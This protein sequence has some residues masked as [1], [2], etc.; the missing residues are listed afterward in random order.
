M[1]RQLKM[2]TLH[3]SSCTVFVSNTYFI[4][5]IAI[6]LVFLILQSFFR[7]IGSIRWRC[8]TL[9]WRQLYLKI[10]TLPSFTGF[11]YWAEIRN[12]CV[13]LADTCH[14][15]PL[16]PSLSLSLSPLSHVFSAMILPYSWRDDSVSMRPKD[17]LWPSNNLGCLVTSLQQASESLLG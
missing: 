14:C 2:P 11:V 6:N 1:N 8:C 9:R 3:S 10:W 5:Q 7:T 12:R 15:V 17:M 13:T 4:Y 16:I